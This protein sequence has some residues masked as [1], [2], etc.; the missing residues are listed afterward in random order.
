MHVR[1]HSPK[2]TL[3]HT[4]AGA[5]THM[6]RRETHGANAKRSR[7]CSLG[8]SC[9]SQMSPD[10]ESVP[11]GVCLAILECLFA[12]PVWPGP[13]SG[14]LRGWQ[15]G[16]LSCWEEAGN[17]YLESDP[18]KQLEQEEMPEGRCPGRSWAEPVITPF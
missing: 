3:T 17:N 12:N 1:I 4:R 5:Y 15:R 16:E 7:A 10:D 11:R 14:L 6:Y 13:S 9:S 18:G 2:H 8:L